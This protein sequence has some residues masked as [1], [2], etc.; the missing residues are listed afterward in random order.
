MPFCFVPFSYSLLFMIV[1]NLDF[2]WKIVTCTQWSW[3]PGTGGGVTLE[4]NQ[5]GDLARENGTQKYPDFL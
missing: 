1:L 4:Y 3:V 5:Q 2:Q